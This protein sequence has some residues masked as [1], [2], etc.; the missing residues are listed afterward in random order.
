M[1]WFSGA[2]DFRPEVDQ[3]IWSKRWQVFL[4]LLL[5]AGNTRT[6]D[7]MQ[8][9]YWHQWVEGKTSSAL[10]AMSE[11]ATCASGVFVFVPMADREHHHHAPKA[12]VADNHR[13][14]QVE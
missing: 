2:L 12:T 3:S 4:T 13:M 14:C 9:Q 1:L 5:E 10:V 8:V 11:T 7:F 6:F